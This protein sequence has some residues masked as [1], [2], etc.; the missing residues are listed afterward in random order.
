MKFRTYLLFYVFSFIICSA[1]P[2][3]EEPIIAHAETP[4]LV[5]NNNNSFSLKILEESKQ[6]VEKTNAIITITKNEVIQEQEIYVTSKN[7]QESSSY[8]LYSFDLYLPN[9]KSLELISNECYKLTKERNR[10]NS[11]TPSFKQNGNRYSFE[12]KYELYKNEY[13]IVKYKYKVTKSNKEKL[14]RQEMIS[15]HGLYKEALCNYQV[16]IPDGYTSLGFENNKFKKQSEKIYVYNDICPNSQLDDVIRLTLDESFW[17]AHYAIYMTSSSKIKGKAKF[18]FPRYYRGGKNIN[19]NYDLETLEKNK[20]NENDLIN[21]ETNL[22]V[23]VPGNKKKKVGVHLHTVFTNKISKDFSIYFSEKFYE[24]QKI[25]NEIK[26]KAQQVIKDTEYGDKPDYYKIGKF[27]YNYLT[28]DYDYSGKE[29]SAHEIFKK[30]R[31]VCEHFTILY[32]AMLNAIGIKTLKVYGWAFKDDETSATEEDDG[33]AWTAAFIDN[34]KWIELDST[35][36]L[37]D[38]ITAGHI[39]QGFGDDKFLYEYKNKAFSFSLGTLYAAEKERIQLIDDLDNFE[40]EE[41][42]VKGN[43]LQIS[44]II[45]IL[46]LLIFFL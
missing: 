29:L 7:L 36:G 41:F 15:I 22:K 35:W 12:Y 25:D 43:Y 18:T 1:P 26:E 6:I 42:Y 27:V 45:Y 2:K 5:T 28:Y 19:K 32:N 4:I 24:I 34:N 33:H 8:T 21:D 31:G 9:E 14:Y 10:E 3:R 30:K 17:S 40:E 38:G 39:L 13:I 46:S 44:Y 16:I 23:E 20:L 37:F 11:C